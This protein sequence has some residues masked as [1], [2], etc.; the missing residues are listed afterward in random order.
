[1][2][3][4]DEI[5]Q[6]IVAKSG[7]SKDEVEAKINEKYKKMNM[8]ISLE[9]VAYIVANELGLDIREHAPSS[10]QIKNIIS[11]MNNLTL[12]ARVMKISEPR[13]FSKD[14]KKGVVQYMI[15]GDKTG[16]IRL[17]AWNDQVS[18]LK[19]IKVGDTIKIDK[20]FTKEDINGRA[21]I[22]V[23]NSTSIEKVQE[24]IEIESKTR[25]CDLKENDTGTLRAA[26]VQA[27]EIEPFFYFCP[28]CRS[29]LSKE[30]E[31]FICKKHGE[32]EPARGLMFAGVIDDGTGNMRAIFFTNAA[33][34]LINMSID[35]AYLKGE[36]L[37]KKLR[38]AL[39]KEFI[40]SGVVRKNKFYERNEFIVNEIKDVNVKEEISKL[41]DKLKA[42]GDVNG[43]KEN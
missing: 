13:E 20:A 39:G 8:E 25:I 9:G 35:E 10:I 19:D 29:H 7:L 23:R 38:E 3:K 11:G 17:V 31:K 5:V 32:V 14:D 41:M 37:L 15:L 4:I 18:M 30:N 12:V 40:M 22:R 28:Q 43:G 24:R 16:R 2:A 42:W 33:L 6:N 36:N 27:F 26:F 21:E 34:K 1:M